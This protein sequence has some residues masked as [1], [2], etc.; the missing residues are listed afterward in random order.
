MRINLN[1]IKKASLF[2]I[3]EK[4][5]IRSGIFN[6]LLMNLKFY[7]YPNL[8]SL[9]FQYLFEHIIKTHK[10]LIWVTAS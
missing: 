9:I 2:V 7:Q 6:H 5:I 10:S 4:S 3:K 8:S 1:F